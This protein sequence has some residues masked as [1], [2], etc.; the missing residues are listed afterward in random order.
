MI[1]NPVISSTSRS[2]GLTSDQLQALKPHVIDLQRGVFST[3]GEYSTREEDVAA[4]FDTYLPDFIQ[5]HGGVGVPLV[6]WAHGGLVNE[7]D[8]LRIANDQV[9]WW[10][11]NGAYPVHF[12][13]ESGLAAALVDAVSGM[14]AR[15]ARGLFEDIKDRAIEL[16]M[17]YG[18]GPAV[19]GE[20]KDSARKAS[21]PGGGALY[22]ATRLAGFC[23]ANPGAVTL[24]AIGH[25]A[26]AVFH[27]YLI[28]AAI[29]AGVRSFDTVNLLAPAMRAD[30]FKQNIMPLIDAGITRVSMFTMDRWTELH[31]TCLNVY[32]KSLLY[33]IRAA[34]E[35]EEFCP[36]LGLEECIRADGALNTFFNTPPSP[37]GAD[38]IWSPTTSGPLSDQ[39]GVT[40]HGGFDGD[41]KTMDSLARRVTGQVVIVPYP[42]GRGLPPDLW[43]LPAPSTLPLAPVPAASRR[44]LC[45][46]INDYPGALRLSGCVADAD[47]WG[48]QFT[49]LGYEVEKLTDQEAKREKILGR[50]LALVS[51]SRA[52]DV[53]AIQ[54]SGH[55]TYVPDLTGDDD[56]PGWPYE[57]AICPADYQAGNLIIDDDLGAIFDLIPDGVNVTC[58]FDSCHSGE[59]TRSAPPLSEAALA[60]LGASGAGQGRRPRFMYPTDEIVAA[61][62]AQRG[63][64]LTQGKRTTMREVLFSAC[65]AQEV[66]YE[67]GGHGDFTAAATVLVIGCSGKVSNG[68]FQQQIRRK[69]RDQP[70]QNPELDASDISTAR[71]FLGTLAAVNGPATDGQAALEGVNRPTPEA[72]AAADR[73]LSAATFLRATADF[74]EGG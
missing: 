7:G 39:S 68:D 69:F 34:L 67:T 18:P 5:E 59:S 2:S 32:G 12:V 37:T 8:G 11:S 71:T 64:P 43:T 74:I 16:A 62:K 72:S 26:G 50:V 41:Q 42:A 53:I 65:G 40:S 29:E 27:S 15:G 44:A 66:A 28:P 22:F 58:F 20:M 47:A 45:I 10:K 55:G 6:I 51:E 23:A 52:G 73:A 17:R 13:W 30:L 38:V 35:P 49:V 31:D 33:L 14:I 61:Y 21:D 36:I 56:T 54:Y 19:W 24:H 4:I 46:G 63:V 9:D 1:L 25:S 3:E 70:R 48:S 60:R 57:Q